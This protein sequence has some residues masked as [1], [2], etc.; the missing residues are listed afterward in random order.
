MKLKIAFSLLRMEQ[1]YVGNI[2]ASSS[3][4]PVAYWNEISQSLGLDMSQSQL[5][6]QIPQQIQMYFRTHSNPLRPAV[7]WFHFIL[8]LF[9]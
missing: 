3:C 4:C 8:S 1:L 7:A 5:C 9:L 2:D 6:H